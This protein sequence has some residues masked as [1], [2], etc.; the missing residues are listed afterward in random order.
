MR[1]HS[2]SVAVCIVCALIAACAT[3]TRLE[4]EEQWEYTVTESQRIGRP[5]LKTGALRFRE[6][7]ISSYFSTVIIGSRRFEYV[8]RSDDE[9]FSG[10]RLDEEWNGDP[11]E[12][13]G[14]SVGRTVR[15]RGWYFADYDELRPETPGGWIWVRRENL[16]AWVDPTAIET[17]AETHQLAAMHRPPP[18]PRSRVRV[19]VSVRQTFGTRR[20]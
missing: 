15:N 19:S 2:K 20:R 7:Q 13:V 9:P 3:T 17:F 1:S 6:R 8:I 4:P 12:P 11:P 5:A 16:E 14:E 18:P 10:Y